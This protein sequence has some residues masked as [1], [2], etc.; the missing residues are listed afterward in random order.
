MI[1]VDPIALKGQ[2]RPANWL[3]FSLAQHRLEMLYN[4]LESRL[5]LFHI[6]QV[7]PEFSLILGHPC[8]GV[9]DGVR[10]ALPAECNPLDNAVRAS[11]ECDLP[12]I[13]EQ[14]KMLLDLGPF[15]CLRGSGEN[16][17]LGL[18]FG[19]GSSDHKYKATLPFIFRAD[20]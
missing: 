14:A 5:R 1:N 8:K 7:E 20:C 11:D 10:K 4:F 13:R 18:P 6:P 12:G 15:P 3:L 19:S 16:D 17:A 9:H 2:S